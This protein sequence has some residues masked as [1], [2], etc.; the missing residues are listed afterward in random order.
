[1]FALHCFVCLIDCLFV[2][3]STDVLMYVYLLQVDVYSFG[4]IMHELV[5]SEIPF[6]KLQPETV[7][8]KVINVEFVIVVVVVVM[9]DNFQH[10]LR[11]KA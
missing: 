9:I 8:A 1:L 7:A 4:I 6:A 10:R 3:L 2:C 11:L 5:A